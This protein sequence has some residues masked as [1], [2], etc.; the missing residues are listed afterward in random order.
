MGEWDSRMTHGLQPLPKVQPVE[1]ANLGKLTTSL[2]TDH[3]CG[4]STLKFRS[5]T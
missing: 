2:G 5:K 1:I 4:D 3:N